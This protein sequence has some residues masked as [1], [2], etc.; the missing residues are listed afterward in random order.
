[1]SKLQER[2]TLQEERVLR[3][4]GIEW[5]DSYGYVLDYDAIT[6]ASITVDYEEITNIL[7]Q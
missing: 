7:K 5:D 3:L 6:G 1:M 2:K 4:K